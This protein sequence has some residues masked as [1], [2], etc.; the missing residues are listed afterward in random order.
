[1]IQRLDE[2]VAHGPLA[3]PRAAERKP[4]RAGT[5]DPVAASPQP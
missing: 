5:V 1:M 4:A 3:R 2:A